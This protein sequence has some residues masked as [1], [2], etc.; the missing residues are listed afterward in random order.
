VIRSG[1]RGEA[2]CGGLKVV[3]TK[4][5]LSKIIPSYS[6]SRP[7]LIHRIIIWIGSGVFRG[8]NLA[9]NRA[10]NRES[11]LHLKV[12]NHCLKGSFLLRGDCKEHEGLGQAY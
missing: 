8:R 2:F 7:G 5:I 6:S 12:N 4:A 10:S 11:A 1:A 9:A 3:L